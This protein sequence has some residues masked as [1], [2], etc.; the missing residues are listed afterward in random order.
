M[1]SLALVLG[2]RRRKTGNLDAAVAISQPRTGSRRFGGVGQSFKLVEVS[3]FRHFVF[4]FCPSFRDQQAH[5]V[6]ASAAAYL[7]SKRETAA[8]DVIR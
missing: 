3:N 6:D 1:R 5:R 2:G 8:R 7:L 4:H